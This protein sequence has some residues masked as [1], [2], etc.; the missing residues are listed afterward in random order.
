[1]STRRK[2]NAAPSLLAA[3][4][5][6]RGEGIIESMFWITLVLAIPALALAAA[7]WGVVRRKWYG[8]LPLLVIAPVGW[9]FGA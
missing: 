4:K 9:L 3:E 8:V 5:W 6:R 7:V 2:V 1:M